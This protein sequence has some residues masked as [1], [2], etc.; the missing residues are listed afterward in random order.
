MLRPDYPLTTERLVLRPFTPDDFEALYA[1]QSLPEVTR[2]LYWETRTPEES[3]EALTSRMS[4]DVLTTQGQNLV[5]AVYWPEADA[6]VGE[7]NL[8]WVSEQHRQGEVGYVFHPIYHG[9]GLAREATEVMLRLGFEE[10]GLH[11]IAAH[12]EARNEPSWRLMERLGMR[13]EA[14]LVQNEFFKGEWSDEL[15]YAM[16]ADEWQARAGVTNR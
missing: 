6:V 3:R 8:H 4:S 14:H 7:V 9:K 1:Y 5:L 2:F 12:C 15:V 11:R 10:L 16:L 13:R